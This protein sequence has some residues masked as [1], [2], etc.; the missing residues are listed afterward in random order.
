MKKKKFYFII[1]TFIFIELISFFAYQSYIQNLI[2]IEGTE[3]LF[4][5]YEQINNTFTLFV[6]RNWN[7][8]S[9]WN[10]RLSSI[11][12]SEQ[13]ISIW[14]DLAY[15][16]DSWNVSDFYLFNE[17]TYFMTASSRSGSA[18]SINNIFTEMYEEHKSVISTYIST[19]NERKI[20]F[21]TPL[22]KPIT[23]DGVTYT[24]IAVSYNPDIIRTVISATSTNRI[25]DSY[26]VNTNGDVIFA[27]EYKT[28]IPEFISNFNDYMTDY[29]TFQT[30]YSNQYFKEHIQ[31]LEKTSIKVNYNGSD[32]YLL[33]LPVG[34]DDWS[35]IAMVDVNSVCG[36]LIKVQAITLLS[37]LALAIIASFLL[38]WIFLHK[39]QEKIN[40]QKT[41]LQETI[42][43][44][45]RLY[46]EKEL[47]EV[48]LTGFKQIVTRYAVGYLKNDTYEYYG[49]E[50]SPLYPRQGKYDDLINAISKN[51][52][53]L[54]DPDHIKLYDLLSK[55][56]LQE[57]MKSTKDIMMIEYAK[58][59]E[60]LFLMMNV[61]PLEFENGVVTKVMLVGQDIGAQHELENLAN[62][63]GLTGLFNERFFSTTLHQK[64]LENHPFIL[65][66]L[67]LDHFKDV[68]DT[69]GHDTG[70]KLLKEVASRLQH[71]TRSD[72]FVFR[73][74]GDEFTII[75]NQ[76]SN[77][78]AEK[79][80]ERIHSAIEKPYVFDDI[81]LNI[82]TSC[83][84]A[85][86]PFDTTDESKLRI[87]ADQRMYTNKQMRHASR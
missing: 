55:E 17:D 86:Y 76:S 63:D 53:V 32:Y 87:I 79:V 25:S 11:E 18:N 59:C 34:I 66:Y 8:L 46:S 68:N 21:A 73:I 36:A 31:S 52:I 48:L 62:T 39:T 42:L 60:N 54:N 70:D 71:C 3:N 15:T 56:Y 7:L 16:K 19:N 5:T 9:D 20:V 74:G 83:G 64:A 77:E 14:K 23:Y 85:I 81:T 28:I 27:L 75:F 41:T 12:D 6:Q 44:N 2:Y 43:E 78:F 58:R 49:Q 69:Y 65:F 40:T 51:Y 47:K 80:I 38:I 33:S 1:A 4:S 26:I 57:H 67:D 35:I 10:N 72:D 24:G 30:N 13:A 50:D 61:I 45:N 84:Y 22:D 82:G 37:I 29:F